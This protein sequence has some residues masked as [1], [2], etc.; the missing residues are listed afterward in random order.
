[1]KNLLN[2][3]V[4]QMQIGLVA[5]LPSSGDYENMAVMEVFFRYLFAY[6]T[7]K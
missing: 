1:M 6:P 4:R 3:L 7:S 5:N 2:T